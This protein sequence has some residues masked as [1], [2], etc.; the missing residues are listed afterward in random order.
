MDPGEKAL[1]KSGENSIALRIENVEAENKR[2][3]Y[4]YML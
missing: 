1:S 2:A 4:Y 3:S